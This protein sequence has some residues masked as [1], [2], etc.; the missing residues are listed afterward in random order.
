MTKRCVIYTRASLDHTG[1]GRSVDRQAEACQKLAEMRGWIVVGVES[2]NSISAYGDTVRPGWERVLK[3]IAEGEVD[4]VVAWHLDRMTRSM[5]RLE[6]LILLT[7]KHQVGIATATGDIDLTTD[8][9]R[10][11][12]RILAAVAR[13]EV[14]RKAARQKLA[15]QQMASDGRAW[16]GGT[17]PF[18]Y[19][20]AQSETVE[21]EARALQW[22]AQ[23]VLAGGTLADVAREWNTR[24]LLSSKPGKD[25]WTV[26]GVKAALVSPRYIGMRVYKGNV[27]KMG[28]WPAIFDEDTHHALRRLLQ[29]PVRSASASRAGRRAQ[30]LL[31]GL[32]TCADCGAGMTTTNRKGVKHYT[33]SART[34]CVTLRAELIEQRVVEETVGLLGSSAVFG[35]LVESGDE[36]EVDAGTELDVLRGR[37]EVLT[38]SFTDGEIPAEVFK[39]SSRKLTEQIERIETVLQRVRDNEVFAGIEL[40]SGVAQVQAAWQTLTLVQQRA[41]LEAVMRIEVR[42]ANARRGGQVRWSPDLHLV[43]EPISAA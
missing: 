35:L 18:G 37:L 21:D 3:M 32:A 8:V 17:R 39:R 13:A 1:E 23:Y 30:S 22:A 4:V 6:E 40:G 43:V 34:H 26:S 10:M 28:Q 33:C 19:N 29:N 2:D 7:E 24:G 16:T 12:A 14:E 42:R 5:M 36:A 9:G 25:G 38:D 41:I 31:S 15:H 11:V 20:R 27:T